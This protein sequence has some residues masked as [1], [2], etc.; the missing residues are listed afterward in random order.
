MF[1]RAIPLVFYF[2]GHSYFLEIG[3]EQFAENIIKKLF[4]TRKGW[5]P[6]T[7]KERVSLSIRS[8]SEDFQDSH[9]AAC[10][11]DLR[12]LFSERGEKEEV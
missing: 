3:R 6:E 12:R 7:W 9:N 1:L 8:P 11:T 10:M 4:L 5:F 2:F